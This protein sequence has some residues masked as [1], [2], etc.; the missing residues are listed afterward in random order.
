M[1]D[2]TT[3]ARNPVI[4]SWHPRWEQVRE[5][6]MKWWN[7]EGLVFNCTAPLPESRDE[8][9]RGV[10]RPE[11]PEVMFDRWFDP[12]YRTEDAYWVAA[13]THW[14]GDAIPLM[15]MITGPGELAA[16]LGSEWGLGDETVWYEPC[17]TD[18]DV[19]NDTPIVFDPSNKSHQTLMRMLKAALEKSQGR[20][21]V[22]VTDLIEHFDI[23]AAMRDPQTF[24]MDLFENGDW[25]HRRLKELNQAYFEI[26]QAYY[27]LLKDDE[28]SVY[29]EAFMAWGRGKTAKVQ[30]DACSMISPD[31][32]REF[33]QPYL[34]EQCDWLDYSMY[35]LDGEECWVH[36]DAL[37][38][39]ESLN[40]IEWT[41]KMLALGEGGGKPKW[42]DLYRRLLDGG[43]S[44][45]AI[46][47]E[48][49]EV[50]PLL[51]AV[52]GK[53][54][55]ICTIAPDVDTAERLAEQ[56]DAYR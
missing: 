33:V 30:C 38:E 9:L 6:H 56:V 43:K 4:P 14:A 15:P 51:D 8:A 34:R 41:P 12:T 54:M 28:G 44:V 17:L 52:G 35:H 25:I 18:E 29:F 2:S 20:L 42:F 22:G 32:F 21:F 39:I 27:D 16:I 26:Y 36:I 45:Q 46:A 7:Q 47:V 13:Q 48:P 19:A 55:Y 50:I 5:N 31:M 49:D 3:T 40:A 11:R 10:P 23:L 24:M 1:P 53:G 37:L